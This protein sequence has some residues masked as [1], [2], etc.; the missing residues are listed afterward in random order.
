[1]IQL[2]FIENVKDVLKEDKTVIGAAIGGS[3]LTNEL[4]E[5]SDVDLVVVTKEKVT[6]DKAKMLGYAKRFGNL[7][8]GFTGEH[9]GEPRLLVCLYGNPLLH[10]DIKFLTLEEVAPR[11]ETPDIILD[12]DN[13]IKNAYMSL[14]ATYPYPDYQWIE[15]RF[16][17]WVHYLLVK[18][19]RGE[20]MEAFDGLNFLRSVVLS[21][22]LQVK[23]GKRPRG[24]RKVE[25]ELSNSDLDDLRSTIPSY[26]K[27]SLLNA[28]KN[29]VALYRNL[30]GLLYNKG[31]IRKDE[32][33]KSVTAY[34]K[35]FEAKAAGKVKKEKQERR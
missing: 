32:A 11:I 13:L 24:V 30:R 10:V 33:E 29:S 2:A 12:T 1:M 34:L 23:N 22:L 3:W 28:L 4:D 19:G 27:I 15:D 7:L 21:P 5:Y 6:D 14:E 9:V 18:I 20:Y 25:F 26:S 8:S 17:V 16:W 31:I 35:T